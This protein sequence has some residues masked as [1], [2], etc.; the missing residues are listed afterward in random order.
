M[1]EKIEIKMKFKNK[2]SEVGEKIASLSTFVWAIIIFVFAGIS[3]T[4]NIVLK[5]GCPVK[6]ILGVPCPFCGM[7]RA[8]L[9]L[10]RLDF[11]V[12]FEYNP[13]FPV[14]ALICLTGI[15]AAADKKRTKIWLTAFFL[16]IALL[17]AVWLIRL[18]T[19]TAV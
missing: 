4:L 16:L 18:I 1:K 2:I 9:S 11:S 5:I 14:F 6:A 12:A 19:G 3:I 15:L 17:I 13:A 8:Y 10:I 7:T